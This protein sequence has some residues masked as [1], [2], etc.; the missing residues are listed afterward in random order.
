MTVTI[1]LPESIRILLHNKDIRDIE[2]FVIDL[3]YK[4][5]EEH[6][7]LNKEEELLIEENLKGLGYI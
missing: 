4:Y 1:T 5:I 2:T 6:Q 7:E 3:I